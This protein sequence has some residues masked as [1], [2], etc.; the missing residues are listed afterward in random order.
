MVQWFQNSLWRLISQKA[1]W[2]EEIHC[3]IWIQNKI[4]YWNWTGW[5][6]K[7]RKKRPSVHTYPLESTYIFH[8]SNI[9]SILLLSCSSYFSSLA[10]PRTD[11]IT[12][13]EL[14]R[15]SSKKRTTCILK[16]IYL[17]FCSVE[18][19]EKLEAKKISFVAV[20]AQNIRLLCSGGDLL[21]CPR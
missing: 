20:R 13:F 10:S 19:G 7:R 14:K 1:K 15:K 18:E 16:T 17:C 11:L 8:P 12:Q 5:L 4:F 6:K 3:V 9:D 2:T 21:K